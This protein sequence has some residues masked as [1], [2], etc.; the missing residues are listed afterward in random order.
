M[1]TGK[2]NKSPQRSWSLCSQRN[3]KGQPS[4]TE[5]IQTIT[6]LSNSM[7]TALKNLLLHAHPINKG[8]VGRL[9]FHPHPQ[10]WQGAPPAS[11]SRMVALWGAINVMPVPYDVSKRT[12]MKW[13]SLSASWCQQRSSGEPEF[14]FPPSSKGTPPRPRIVNG[15]KVGTCSSTPTWQWQGSTSLSPPEQCQIVLLKRK[16]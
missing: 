13:P 14:P 7:Q 15:G 4:K 10:L 12:V 6:A 5:N 2:G 3:R 8:H 11:P 1:P 9:D 16:I